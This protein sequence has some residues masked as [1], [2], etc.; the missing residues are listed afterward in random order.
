MSIRV[1]WTDETNSHTRGCE[2]LL[3]SE[4]LAVRYICSLKNERVLGPFPHKTIISFPDEQITDPSFITV[5]TRTQGKRVEELQEVMLCMQAQTCQDYAHLIV[6]HNVNDD[7]IDNIVNLIQNQPKEYQHR[8]SL[9]SAEG[10]DRS[11]PLNVAISTANTSYITFL[12]DDDLV[13]PNWIQVFRDCALDHFGQIIHSYVAT[14]EWS[15]MS[16]R[17]QTSMTASGPMDR[18]YCRPYNWL[19]QLS[20]NYCPIMSL[21]YPLSVIREC[22]LNFDESLSTNEDW[23][24]LLQAARLCGVCE[25][26]EVTSIYRLWTNSTNS[27]SSHSLSEWERNRLRAQNNICRQP[28]AIPGSE[29]RNLIELW[30]HHAFSWK[31]WEDDI[32]LEVDGSDGKKITVRPDLQYESETTR[33]TATFDL[34]SIEDIEFLRLYLFHHPIALFSNLSIEL[35]SKLGASRVISLLETRHNGFEL[36]NDAIAFVRYDPLLSIAVPKDALYRRLVFSFTFSNVVSNRLLAGKKLIPRAKKRLR[37]MLYRLFKI[38][39]W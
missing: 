5:V 15:L 1:K 3:P 9:I 8:V 32:A 26:Q 37:H 4:S 39:W 25:V 28:A 21:A 7:G 13:F 6:A 38:E 11:R 33:I 12:D 27:Y 19:E 20:T 18:T 10:G 34:T 35:H 36:S 2:L 24:F 31:L 23:D 22:G 16:N 29:I 14:Q 17:G 30:E